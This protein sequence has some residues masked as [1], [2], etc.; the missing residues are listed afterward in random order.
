MND[1]EEATSEARWALIAGACEETGRQAAHALARH[2]VNL[3]LVDINGSELNALNDEI[4][5]SFDVESECHVMNLCENL[6]A[7]VLAL[8]CDDADILIVCPAPAPMGGLMEL[9]NDDWRKGFESRVTATISL[10]REF[11]ETL[12]ERGAGIII[13]DL[14]LPE[15]DLESDNILHSATGGALSA[16]VHVLEKQSAETGIRVLEIDASTAGEVIDGLI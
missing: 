5:R 9:E 16:L 6:N 7:E 1:E 3:H 12:L 14:S 11:Y 4:E 8:E 15:T 10:V 2:G 13:I